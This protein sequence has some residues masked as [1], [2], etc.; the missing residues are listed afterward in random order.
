MALY[1]FYDKGRLLKD[2]QST[3]T[4]NGSS[5]GSDSIMF[6]ST[7]SYSSGWSSPFGSE[8]GSTETEGEEDQDDGEFIAKLTRQMADYM[9]EEEEEDENEN[10]ATKILTGSDSELVPTERHGRRLQSP[11]RTSTSCPA[12]GSKGFFDNPSQA[13]HLYKLENQPVANQQDSVCWGRRMTR[14][15]LTQHK[16]PHHTKNRGRRSDAASGGGGGG[17]GPQLQQRRQ[18]GSGSGMRAV[19]LGGPPGSSSGSC[20]TGVFL[21]R[22]TTPVE[23]RKKSGTQEKKMRL[24]ILQ[25]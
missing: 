9:L 14:T 10:A 15:E 5:T 1:D 22:G 4:R 21:P 12:H 11:I 13:V 16:K 17:F 23:V 6:G 8:L 25:V 3:M 2:E 7:G 20:G 24:Q 18:V 19:F